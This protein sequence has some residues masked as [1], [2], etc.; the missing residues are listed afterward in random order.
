MSSEREDHPMAGAISP[1]RT[2][3]PF[4]RSPMTAG[5]GFDGA[6][7]RAARDALG[8]SQRHLAGQIG[9]TSHDISRWEN[10]HQQPTLRAAVVLA[11]ALHVRVED[12]T[13]GA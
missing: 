8:V 11:R 3:Q 4:G 5:A 6:A 7:L 12:L 1:H 13:Y 2:R 10:G 9:C